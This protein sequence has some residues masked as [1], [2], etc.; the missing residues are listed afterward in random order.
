MPSK[1]LLAILAAVSR[2][3]MSLESTKIPN[4]FE[5]EFFLLYISSVLYL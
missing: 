1:I 3:D 2:K 5:H 4:P